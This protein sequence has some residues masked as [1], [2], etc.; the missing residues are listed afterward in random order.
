MKDTIYYPKASK[1][2]APSLYLEEISNTLKYTLRINEISEAKI[3]NLLD[4]TEYNDTLAISII[5]AVKESTDA[6]C[7][8]FFSAIPDFFGHVFET[9]KTK[10][11]S[12]EE[13]KSAEKLPEVK[14]T[15]LLWSSLFNDA[16]LSVYSYLRKT[17]CSGILRGYSAYKYSHFYNG[18]ETGLDYLLEKGRHYFSYDSLDSSKFELVEKK[19]RNKESNIPEGKC[20]Q[21]CHRLIDVDNLLLNQP[22]YQKIVSI[23]AKKSLRNTVSQDFTEHNNYHVSCDGAFV[24]NIL[25]SSKPRLNRLTAWVNGGKSPTRADLTDDLEALKNEYRGRTGYCLSD[26]AYLEQEIENLFHGEVLNSLWTNIHEFEERNGL[27]LNTSDLQV[28][29]LCMKL[30]LTPERPSIIHYAFDFVLTDET[31]QE[32]FF[33]T[34]DDTRAA[35]IYTSP[36]DRSR[37]MDLW[38]KRY[39]YMMNYLSAFAYP[40]YR[41][42]F[43]VNLHKVI[44]KALN[45]NDMMKV[46]PQMYNC[47]RHCINYKCA[48]DGDNK[49]DPLQQEMKTQGTNNEQTKGADIPAVRK[50][51]KGFGRFYKDCNSFYRDLIR[52]N[53]PGV[54]LTLEEL[55]RFS[56]DVKHINQLYDDA[57]ADIA[58]LPGCIT[59]T[60]NGFMKAAARYSS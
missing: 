54:F 56:L 2:E 29:S 17:L 38:M 25:C 52:Q 40:V 23:E 42:C 19:Q 26:C 36:A 28:L 33:S 35:A 13:Q 55:D 21:F 57:K 3:N 18:G 41:S 34:L 8:F 1:K 15:A 5:D 50:A 58:I 20:T 30:P 11:I 60:R 24:G 31:S 43:L 46:I 45:T 14:L 4:G 22:G 47:L 32:D 44:C 12:L 53:R 37:S 9:Q 49:S 59:K 39:Q 10:K 48:E 16:L 6:A 7:Q 27:E 51:D